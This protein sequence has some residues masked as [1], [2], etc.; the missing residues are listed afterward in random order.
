M[1]IGE[2]FRWKIKKKRM[3]NWGNEKSDKWEIMKKGYRENGYWEKE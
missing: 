1:E 3:G 2:N